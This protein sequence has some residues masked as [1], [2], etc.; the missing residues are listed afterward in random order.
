[1]TGN[2]FR[3]LVTINGKNVVLLHDE[4]PVKNAGVAE[5]GDMFHMLNIFDGKFQPSNY[6]KADGTPLR[7]FDAKT[8]KVDLSKRSKEDMGFWHRNVDAHEI[9][10]CVKG[11]LRWETEMGVKTMHEGD[12]MFIPKG[13]AHR[14]MLCEDSLPENVLVEL[15]IVDEVTYVGG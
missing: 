6:N 2:K 8:V 4:P 5:N 10:I 14:S 12:M 7:M 13:I 3:E 15:K 1:M 11:A 9:I